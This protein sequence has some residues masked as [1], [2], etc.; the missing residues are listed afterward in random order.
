M[1]DRSARAIAFSLRHERNGIGPF[2]DSLSSASAIASLYLTAGHAMLAQ[3]RNTSAALCARCALTHTPSLAAA[4]HLLG[5]ALAALHRPYA[6]LRSLR[7]AAALA[8]HDA[9]VYR[10]IGRTLSVVG[11]MDAAM[12]T[13]RLAA[14]VKP[15]DPAAW[16]EAG[17]VYRRAGLPGQAA[18]CLVQAHRLHP[19]RGDTLV[20]LGLVLHG[21]GESVGATA[22][23]RMALTIDPSHAPALRA[24]AEVTGASVW[25]RRADPAPPVPAMPATPGGRR[26]AVPEWA[27]Q[28][29]AGRS[30][31]L[32]TGGDD[33]DVVAASRYSDLIRAADSVVIE[34]GRR[35]L[36]LF[37]R[38]FPRA[39]IRP[40]Q[41]DTH[42]IPWEVVN[43]DLHASATTLLRRLPAFPLRS[44]WLYA[45]GRCIAEWHGR[46]DEVGGGRL[47][48]GMAWRGVPGAEP[49]RWGAVMMTAG[50]T[51]VSLQPGG[52]SA[53]IT[54]AERRFGVPVHRWRGLDLMENMEQTAALITALDVV[55]APPGP[56][57]DLAGALGVPVWCLDPAPAT[58]QG[59]SARRPALHPS[60][61]RRF[62]AHTAGH[63]RNALVRIGQDMR[64]LT[65]G[66]AASA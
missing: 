44:S 66:E 15:A 39:V 20:Q 18:A 21:E 56:V 12:N 13:L 50:V 43:C 64:R 27:G 29:L 10:D 30:L 46:L 26:L 48:V 42:A 34:C 63:T 65:R 55:V 40:R 17:Q 53:E 11:E 8:P 35:H 4:H 60:T 3:R 33:E 24:L 31:F 36:S 58:E 37:A 57:A 19:N 7:T 2:A 62:C 23:F 38:S 6:A 59:W 9:A 52:G 41:P 28:P 45:D 1:D 25:S 32:W 47:R 22:C 14:L 54:A 16:V 51:L 61:R 5:E 49:E